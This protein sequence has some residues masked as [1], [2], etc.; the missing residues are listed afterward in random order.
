MPIAQTKIVWVCVDGSEFD[1]EA[2]AVHYESKI[3]LVA[4]MESTDIHWR[5]VSPDDVAEWLLSEYTITRK[6]KQTGV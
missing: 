2:A 3:A 4:D 5:D 6:N 1:S